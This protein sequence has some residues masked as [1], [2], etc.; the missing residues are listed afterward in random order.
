MQGVRAIPVDLL[1]RLL[2]SMGFNA[3]QLDSVTVGGFLELSNHQGPVHDGLED[4]D[5]LHQGM[6]LSL[7][8]IIT[9]S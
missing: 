2:E 8:T 1:T 5:S 3:T 4:E 9:L 7:N 6:C